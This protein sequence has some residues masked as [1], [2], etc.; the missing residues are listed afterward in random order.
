MSTEQQSGDEQSADSEADE[1]PDIRAQHRQAQA[2]GEVF[3][4]RPHG[5][6]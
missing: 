1:Q 2:S 3:E 4:G 6:R 5:N